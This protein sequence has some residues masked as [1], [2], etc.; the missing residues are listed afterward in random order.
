MKIIIWI[1][2]DQL[3]N[4]L[5]IASG[6]IGESVEYWEREPGMFEKT[7]QVIVDLDTYQKLQDSRVITEINPKPYE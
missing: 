7:I 2:K 1:E 3:N 5:K 4:L 6:Y